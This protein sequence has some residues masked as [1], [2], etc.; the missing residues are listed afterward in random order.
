MVGLAFRVGC[1]GVLGEP[2][3]IRYKCLRQVAHR[4]LGKRRIWTA[5]GGGG[6]FHWFS[7]PANP[8]GFVHGSSFIN[9]KLLTTT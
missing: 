6:P 2:Q 3:L 9:N 4:I 7:N 5:V 8:G 1:L